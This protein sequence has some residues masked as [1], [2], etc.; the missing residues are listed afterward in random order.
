MDEPENEL[1][2]M[3]HIHGTDGFFIAA[4]RRRF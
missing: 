4:F 1:T 2:L 3:P